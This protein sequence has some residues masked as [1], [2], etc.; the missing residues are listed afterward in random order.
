MIP[1]SILP[2]NYM[3]SFIPVIGMILKITK[4]DAGEEGFILVIGMI[5]IVRL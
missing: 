5:L 3:D 2:V 4:N 1:N